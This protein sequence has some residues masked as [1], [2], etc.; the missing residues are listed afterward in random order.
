MSKTPRR[1]SAAGKSTNI[2]N[3]RTIT[4][5]TLGSTNAVLAGQLL[6]R[7]LRRIKDSCH[8]FDDTLMG[9]LLDALALEFF[10]PS[11]EV[12]EQQYG[13]QI[14][15]T[16][17]VSGAAAALFCNAKNYQLA[18]TRGLGAVSIPDGSTTRIRATA[19]EALIEIWSGV[20][21]VAGEAGVDRALNAAL[22]ALAPEP[23]AFPFWKGLDPE[24]FRFVLA[25]TT[26]RNLDRVAADVVTAV[27]RLRDDSAWKEARARIFYN[28]NYGRLIEPLAKALSPDLDAVEA[29]LKLEQVAAGSIGFGGASSN[30]TE[31]KPV[32]PETD[33]P[34]RA[35][36][37]LPERARLAYLQH[38]Q[39]TRAL[40]EDDGRSEA[41]VTDDA[42][43]Q[44]LKETEVG[45]LPPPDTWKRN[46]RTARKALH[47][48]KKKPRTKYDGPS[49]VRPEH[50][51]DRNVEE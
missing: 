6:L 31:Q 2:T 26:A 39:A 45:N 9:E 34:P 16:R 13:S 17:L 37:D 32:D 10:S 12:A 22:S 21:N 29:Q 40:I 23:R 28:H 47:Q 25:M 44:H 51:G 35:L 43:Y 20:L 30:Q 3:S 14:R 15:F 42:A 7:S 5:N 46:L 18:R 48:Q 4:S 50:F 8:T 36:D 11:I 27:T 33:S 19:A 1:E 24:W 49:A 38:R 41:D